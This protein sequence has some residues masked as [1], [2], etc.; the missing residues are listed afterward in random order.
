M[1]RVRY[2]IVVPGLGDGIKKMQL[3]TN[4]WRNHSLEPVVQHMNWR[5][6]ED[7]ISKLNNLTTLVDELSA[8]GTVSIVGTSAGGSAAI[9]T[10]L[11]RRNVIDKVV[12]VCGRLR[13]DTHTGIHSFEARSASSLAFAQ[14][15]ILCEKNQNKLTRAERKR[16]MTI[17]ALLGDELV[18]AS[19]TTIDGANNITIPTPEHMFSITMALTLLSKPLIDFLTKENE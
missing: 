14:S 9:N 8:K 12:N 5:D 6:G 19:T 17:H 7:F 16:V 18:P 3:A 10:F 13:V 4:H 15:V 2:V 1:A 11:E